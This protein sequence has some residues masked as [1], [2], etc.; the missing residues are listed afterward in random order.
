MSRI[1]GAPLVVK[2]YGNRRLYDTA[3]SQYVTLEEL[4]E[5]IRGG[6]DVRVVDAKT[7]ADLTAVTLTQIIVEGRG[8][9]S[10]LPVPLLLQLVRLRDD[11]LAEFFG[12]WMTLALEAYLQ[13]KQGLEAVAPYSPFGGYPFAAPNA[14]GRLFGSMAPMTGWAAPPA[15]A[16]PVTPAEP[17][18][19]SRSHAAARE[20]HDDVADLRREIEELRRAMKGPPA[21]E[22]AGPKRGN[23]PVRKR[24]RGTAT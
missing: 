15:P 5:T 4:A 23:G 11:A 24:G 13:T 18:P 8:A 10:L 2:K 9:A 6:T 16:A 12:R 19:S 3:R 21:R 20:R 22:P 17:A 14:L 7:G 1:E